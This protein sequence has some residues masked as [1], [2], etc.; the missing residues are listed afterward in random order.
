MLVDNPVHHPE[1]DFALDSGRVV[2]SGKNRLTFSG[3]G[4]YQ[5]KLFKD[6]V[7]GSVA[8]LAPLLPRR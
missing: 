6:I 2:L 1:G 8:K 3:I 4:I 5:P 7:P